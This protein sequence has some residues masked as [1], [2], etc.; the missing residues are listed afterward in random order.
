M[1]RQ[2]LV[3]AYS[4]ILAYDRFQLF[5][6]DKI[7]GEDLQLFVDVASAETQNKIAGLQQISHVT[8]HPLQAGLIGYPAVSALDDF[9]DNCAATDSRDR[10]LARR[11]HVR[12]DDPVC[13]V[14]DAAKLA[15]QRLGS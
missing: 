7:G 2:R 10:H 9:I 12:D 13:V 4:T 1:L 15:G 6:N 5:R 14:E 11:V 3:K 8:M